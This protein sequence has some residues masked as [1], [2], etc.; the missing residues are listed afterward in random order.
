MACIV[1]KVRARAGVRLLTG[2]GEKER[3]R[4]NGLDAFE[5][6]LFIQSIHYIL[7]TVAADAYA[8]EISSQ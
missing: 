3:R 8:G 5:A 6:R 7:I 4:V 2:V 1:K